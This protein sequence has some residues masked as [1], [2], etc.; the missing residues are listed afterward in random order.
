VFWLTVLV[1]GDTEEAFVKAV[2]RPHLEARA[3]YATPIKYET[4][5]NA[6]G[7]R[8]KGGGLRWAGVHKQLREFLRD[9]RAEFRLTTLF[10]LYGLPSD[11]PGMAEH[12]QV[13]STAKRA[14]SLEVAMA[15]ALGDARFIPYI[16]RHEF[17]SLVLACLDQLEASDPTKRSGITKLRADIMGLAPEDVNDGANTAPSKRLA[18]FVDGYRK[19]LDGPEVT[20]KAGLTLLRTACPRFGTWLT[21]LES[22]AGAP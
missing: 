21:T 20:G 16:Q 18:R 9:P 14:E 17:E 4:S 13:A 8:Y 11:F 19:V 7:R 22:L 1:E 3:V 10:D 5:R 2:L 6:E 12:A 15:T